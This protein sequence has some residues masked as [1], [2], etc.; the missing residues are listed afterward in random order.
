MSLDLKNIP[1]VV[2]FELSNP[3]ICVQICNHTKSLPRTCFPSSLARVTSEKSPLAPRYLPIEMIVAVMIILTVMMITVM[4]KMI[5]VMVM[6]IMVMATTITMVSRYLKAA[7]AV[8]SNLFQHKLIL[9]PA[10]LL[11]SQLDNDWKIFCFLISVVR[12]AKRWKGKL[13]LNN[14]IEVVHTIG[15]TFC[16]FYAC[17]FLQFCI[18]ALSKNCK[19][20]FLSCQK[21]LLLTKT[22]T[23]TSISMDLRQRNLT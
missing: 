2:I 21:S 8:S 23:R 3:K 6:T 4:V 19:C 10:I 17:T 15:G 5:T 13:K 16:L 1:E 7:A 20:T 18:L 9:S 12:I 14:T 22:L 11:L